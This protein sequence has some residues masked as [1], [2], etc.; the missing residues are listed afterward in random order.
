MCD[1][2]DQ[3]AR[4][5]FLLLTAGLLA[6]GCQ[7]NSGRGPLS[8]STPSDQTD[9]PQD[10]GTDDFKPREE[11]VGKGSRA[12]F[13]Y[14]PLVLRQTWTKTTPRSG[15]GLNWFDGSPSSKGRTK[16]AVPPN[17]ITVHH[18]AMHWA[19]GHT[20]AKSVDRLRT[21]RNGHLGRGGTIS[22]TTLPLMDEVA[23]GSV[24]RC[25]SR[26]RMSKAKPSKSGHLDDG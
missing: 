3:T 7:Y 19:G 17:R 25:N 16:S 26:A 5:Q 9:D 21:I 8:T 20:F 10:V 4:R 6:A 22:V 11:I 14:G 18:D 13:L 15:D 24:G 2:C 12:N 23:S 1:T